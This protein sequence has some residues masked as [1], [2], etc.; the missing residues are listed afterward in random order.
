[1]KRNQTGSFTDLFF[2]CA[3]N[4]QEEVGDMQLN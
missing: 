3:K 1:M 4:L 2:A